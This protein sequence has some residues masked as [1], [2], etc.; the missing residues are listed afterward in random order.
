MP[1][2]PL[3]P[4]D[5]TDP[6]IEQLGECTVG[7][8][9]W[10]EAVDALKELGFFVVPKLIDALDGAS[11]QTRKGITKALQRMGPMVLYDVIDALAHDSW[12][13]RSEAADFLLG[14][15]A[16]R[17]LPITDIVPALIG[18]LSDRE[19][20]YRLR[21]AQALCMLREKAQSAVPALIEALQ[22]EEGYVRQWVAA[23][24]GAIGPAAEAAIPV[25]TEALLD[26]DEDVRDEASQALD[27]IQGNAV[28]P[29]V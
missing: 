3:N 18:L 14:Q 26:E 17:E 11:L 15:A 10:T 21:A 5:L 28:L 22:D 7:D 6:W 29:W 2:E 24:L 16:R 19:N 4:N 13:V 1:D 9:E 12:E 27:R 8:P 25:Q 23:A 20:P